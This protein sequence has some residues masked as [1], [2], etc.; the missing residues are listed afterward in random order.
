M[1]KTRRSRNEGSIRFV[2]SK[3]LYEGRYVIGIDF[4]GKSIYK[5]IYSKKKKEVVRKMQDALASMGKGEYVDPSG[6]PLL[7]WCKEWYET[8]KEHSL[9]INTQE[10]YKTSMKRL[11]A[12]DIANMR[13]KELSQDLIQR[14]YNGLKKQGKAI[15]TIKAT[16]SLI[17]GALEKAEEIKMISRNPARFVTIPRNDE[18]EICDHDVKALTDEEYDLFMSAMLQRSNYFMYAHFMAN[19]GLRPGEALALDREDINIDKHT[20]QVKKTFIRKTKSVQNATK[21]KSSRR[22]IPIPTSTVNLLKEYMLR[23]KKKEDDAPLFQT[24]SGTRISP[25]NALRAFKEIGS[26]IK[27]PKRSTLEWVNLHTMRHT[28]ASRLFKEDIDIKVIS[29]LLGHSKVST[30]YDIYVHFIDGMVEESIA[31]LNAN[32]PESLPEKTRRISKKDKAKI[33]PLKK[34][35]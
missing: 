21:T 16:H 4:E 15:E 23:S 27:L 8:Y 5:S 32:S 28:Y 22:T 31:V 14:Y 3:G 9:R 25:R 19:T 10:K 2:E 13:L 20:V 35:R 29:E 11:E 6:K 24:L 33:I 26:T 17:N 30:T 1:P 12:A 7:D 18:S 34:A